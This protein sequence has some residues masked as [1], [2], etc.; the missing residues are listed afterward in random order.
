MGYPAAQ[1]HLMASAISFQGY[2]SF[3][4]CFNA[5]TGFDIILREVHL[6]QSLIIKQCS[7][8]DCLEHIKYIANEETIAI[9][10]LRNR[11]I[12]KL[13]LSREY[14]FQICG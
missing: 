3:S 1:Q 4:E 14:F 11:L 13:V 9:L 12:S 5:L 6:Y 10:Y 2:H 7:N 8:T